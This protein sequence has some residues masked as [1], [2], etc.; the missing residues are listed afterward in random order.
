MRLKEKRQFVKLI[1]DCSLQWLGVDFAAT[2]FRYG[3]CR[4]DED[5][6]ACLQM[7]LEIIV[8]VGNAAPVGLTA[9]LILGYE[10]KTGHV[11]VIQ[12]GFLRYGETYWFNQKRQPVCFSRLRGE[13]VPV[14]CRERE[15]MNK[16]MSVA[17][18]AADMLSYMSLAEFE[19]WLVGT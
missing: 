13:F 1:E 6:P 9:L 2:M 7:P 16:A 15:S 17:M 5:L 10:A 4:P 14:A 12:C 3:E 11:S 8:R 19:R 18:R